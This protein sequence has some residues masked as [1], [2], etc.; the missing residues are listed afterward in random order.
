MSSVITS[1]RVY[2]FGGYNNANS[3]YYTAFSNGLNDYTNV[4]QFSTLN[5]GEFMLPD[6]SV[7]DLATYPI[8]NYI[9]Y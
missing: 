3:V 5:A 4:D 7:A 9:K 8:I 6:T 1:S 2:I